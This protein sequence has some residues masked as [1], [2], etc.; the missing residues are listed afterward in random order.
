MCNVILLLLINGYCNEKWETII[1]IMIVI[2]IN[3]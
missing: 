1:V 3:V 2:I